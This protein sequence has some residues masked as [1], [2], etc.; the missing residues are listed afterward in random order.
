MQQ[1]VLPY[2]EEADLGWP[3]PPYA[4]HPIYRRVVETSVLKKLSRPRV[5]LP[6]KHPAGYLCQEGRVKRKL[7]LFV[8]V[9][10]LPI[11][12]IELVFIYR[13]PAT[14]WRNC[15]VDRRQKRASQCI[16]K[17][18]RN[19]GP[20]LAKLSGK[21]IVDLLRREIRSADYSRSPA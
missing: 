18:R 10:S 16:A 7:C 17:V 15:A 4:A 8:L 21:V 12:S 11:T 13:M 14:V 5:R 3:E 20:I 19:V 6:V 1:A 9:Q 2:F